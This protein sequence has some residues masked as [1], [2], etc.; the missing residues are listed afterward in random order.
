MRVPQ[1]FTCLSLTAAIL[2]YAG[3]SRAVQ[4]DDGKGKAQRNQQPKAS[5][6]FKYYEAASLSGI[7]LKP[8][9]NTGTF[10]LQFDQHLTEPGQLEVKNMAGKI[11]YASILE[12]NKE[13][14]TRTL[15]VGR[16]SPG[17]YSIEVKTPDTT[18]WKKVRIR[19]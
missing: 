2:F 19:K 1:L 13:S 6:R 11:L 8:N 18:F 9:K 7:N 10:I 12:A 4:S 17:I 3:E 14:V 16:L 15:D 5:S